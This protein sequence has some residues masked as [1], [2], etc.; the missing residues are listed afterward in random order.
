MRPLLFI[1]ATIPL[2]VIIREAVQGYRFQQ[3]RKVNHLL[4]MDDLKLNG[5]SKDN[6]EALTNTVR[7][8]TEH[9]QNMKFGISKCTAL[10][11]KRGNKMEVEGIQMARWDSYRISGLIKLANILEY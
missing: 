3:G 8:F 10:A 4:Y 6:L 9:E 2:S 7:I 11:M 5:K 1:T